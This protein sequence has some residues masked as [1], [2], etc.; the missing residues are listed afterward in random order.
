[1]ASYIEN[2]TLEDSPPSKR[3]KTVENPVRYIT[4]EDVGITERIN[5]EIAQISAILKQR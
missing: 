3:A 5:K 1:M 4:E 2:D